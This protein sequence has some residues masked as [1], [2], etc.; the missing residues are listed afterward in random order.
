[1]F[2]FATFRLLKID[3]LGVCASSAERRKIGV[4][5]RFILIRIAINTE[6]QRD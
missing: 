6:W 1:M 4:V 3:D 2:V 5:L